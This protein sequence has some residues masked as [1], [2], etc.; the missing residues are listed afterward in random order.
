MSEPFGAQ[1]PQ[2]QQEQPGG[3]RPG[4]AAGVR[5][6]V[7]RRP[8]RWIAAGAAAV[9][10]VGGGAAVAVH[11]AAEGHG[12]HRGPLAAGEEHGGQE[13]GGRGGHDGRG[14]GG[15]GKR[16][17]Q[18][19]HGGPEGRGDH[20]QGGRGQDDHGQD[21]PAPGDRAGRQ[22]P[23]AAPL[24]ALSAADA[25]AKA[26]AAVDGGRVESLTTVSDQGGGRAWRAVVIGP[27]GVRHTVTVDGASGTLTGNTVLGG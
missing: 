25:V 3:G 14:R 27:D 4:R 8:V 10:V 11:H 19:G 1:E 18:R 26:A 20:G 15:D 7:R 17:E 13:G 21:G 12:G 22:G 5:R 24:P 2:E 9:V 23:A 16:D 6:W